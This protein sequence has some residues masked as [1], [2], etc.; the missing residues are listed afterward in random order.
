MESFKV[1]QLKTGALLTYISMGLGF[2]ISLIYT[3]IM[4]RLLGQSEYGLYNLAASV[5]AYLGI[6]NFGFGST[7][8]RYY[9]HFKMKKDVKGINKLNGMFLVIFSVLALITLLSGFALSFFAEIVF[10]NE[11]TEKEISIAKI[12][13]VILTINLALKFL[14]I[15]F[16]SYIRANERFIFQKITSL[17]RTIVNPFVILP[18]LFLGYGSIGMAI[19]VT[20]LSL[21]IEIIHIMYAKIKLKIKF[22]FKVF[23]IVL[24]KEIT[25]FSSFIFLNLVIDQINWNIDKFIIGR[26]HG[27]IPVAIY[28]LSA[29]FN[30]YYIQLSTA[31]SSVF[32]PRVHKLIQSFNGREKI[33]KLFTKVGRVQFIVLSLFLTGFIFFG[34]PFIYWWAG[35]NYSQSYYIIIILISS[36]TIPIIQ[37]LG[38]E[39]SR[40]R[41]LHKFR[42]ITYLLI[43][44]VNIGITIPLV[45]RYEG[46]GAALGTALALLIGNALIMNIYYHKKVGLD[47]LFFWKEIIKLLPAFILPILSGFLLL[48]YTD[49]NQTII[50][51]LDIIT[52]ILVFG[53]SMWLIGMNDFEKDLFR[54]P[55]YVL[56]NKIKG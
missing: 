16:I 5:I 18:I 49:I 41:K 50:F 17:V 3:P 2:L 11:L 30:T 42:S 52:Y 31:I 34:K 33:T 20:V 44:V 43:A 35:D 12:L 23:D 10:G 21:I 19:G 37:N 6:L 28:S 48:F 25:I 26:F 55:L 29:L 53:I 46:I 13:L 1:N 22:S 7:Y 14:D 36:V 47:I 54:K 27:T 15:V 56:V 24:F 8:I 39:I 40:A 4:I 9:L 38:I 32:V 45:V 51:I